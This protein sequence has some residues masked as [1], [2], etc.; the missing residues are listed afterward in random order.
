MLFAASELY[1]IRF[2]VRTDLPVW[3]PDVTTY[4]VFDTDGSHLALLYTDF[5]KRDSKR[6]G[7]WMNSLIGQSRLLGEQPI[8]CN[9]CNYTEPAEGQPALLTSDEVATL[10]HE[11][12]HALH[13]LFSDV[14][15]PSLAG[16]AVPRDFVEFPSQFNEHWGMYPTIFANYAR[17]CVTGEAHAG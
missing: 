16:T 4:E 13:G 3:H 7:A 15:F 1:G 6:G 2:Q 11:F 9:V 17:H 5:F 8:I 14:E 10:F 12:G